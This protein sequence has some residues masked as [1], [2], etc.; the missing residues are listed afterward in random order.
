MKQIYSK[1]SYTS[2]L[3]PVQQYLRSHFYSPPLLPLAII[4]ETFYFSEMRPI[5]QCLRSHHYLSM[6]VST[7]N[8]MPLKST[9]S[10]NSNSSIQIQ[11]AVRLAAVRHQGRVQ[12]RVRKKNWAPN[13]G[14]LSIRDFIYIPKS[15][16]YLGSKGSPRFCM[17]KLPDR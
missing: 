1:K 10:R 6:T 5:Q 8:A 9:K 2:K 4:E 17:D 7:E 14:S 12:M 11:M 16:S 13:T 3:R 15:G